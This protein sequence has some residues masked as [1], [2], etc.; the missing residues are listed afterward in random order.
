MVGCGAMAHWHA[1]ELLKSGVVKIVALV[2]PSPPHAEDFRQQHAPDALIY[3][4]LDTLLEKPPAPIDAIVIVTPHTLHYAQAKTALERG[5]HVLCE[6]PMVTNTADAYDLWQTATRTGKLLSITF[7]SPHT[8]QFGQLR[9]LLDTGE[10]GR[11]YSITGWVSQGW[12]SATRNTW[13]Q[14]PALSGGGFMYDTGAHLLN[15]VMWIM[16]DPV[17]EVGCFVDN[18]NSPV[19]IAGAVCMKFQNGAIASLAFPGDTPTFENDLSLFTATH[20]I[21]TNAYG[22][23]LDIFAKDHSRF[24]VHIPFTGSTTPHANFIATLQGR[25]SLR[26]PARFGVLL[27][28]LMDAMYE[29]GRTGNIVKVKP[30]PKEL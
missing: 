9:Q 10:I 29:S 19:D 18:R 4:S 26:S 13:R 23:K 5:I 21:H 16:N 3:E 28:A 22:H 6:K 8:A 1:K 30:V 24:D 11:I 27:S 7:Q 12:L 15:A 14:D 20:T 2:D 17:V 25:E